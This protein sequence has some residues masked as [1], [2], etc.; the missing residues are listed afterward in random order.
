MD[1]AIIKK[2]VAILTTS[3]DIEYQENTKFRII[4]FFYAVAIKLS[5]RALKGSSEISREVNIVK[6]DSESKIQ[7]TMYI[8]CGPN[9]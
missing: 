9:L 5:T 4:L 8:I 2:Y 7:T 1:L 3:K 6:I